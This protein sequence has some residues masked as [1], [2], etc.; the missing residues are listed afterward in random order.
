M[1]VAYCAVQL[2]HASIVRSRT[3]GDQKYQQVLFL[4]MKSVA[5]TGCDK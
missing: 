4:S 1:T 2:F 5:P 3:I